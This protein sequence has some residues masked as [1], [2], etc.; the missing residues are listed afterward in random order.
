MSYVVELTGHDGT[1][2]TTVRF[3][4]GPGR[5]FSDTT[6]ANSGLVRWASPSQ[7]INVAR[8]G[9]VELSGDAGTLVIQNAP[10]DYLS[11]G[12]WDSLKDWA[13]QRASVYWAPT[14]WA[15]KTLLASARLQQPVSAMAENTLT[16]PM[17]DPRAGLDAALQPTK[18]AGSNVGV[19]GVEGT[20]DIKGKGK[21]ILYGVVSNIPGVRVNESK[22]IY[23][24]ADKAAT[25]LCVRDGAFSLSIGVVR[26]N[27]A[28]MQ[29]TAPD[30]GKYDTYAG[31]EGTFVRLCSTPIKTVTFDAQEGAAEANRTHAQIWKRVRT[32]RCG[33]VSGDIEDASVTATDAV[34]P[35]EVG[36]WWANDETMLDAL[37]EVL[38][39]LS[40]YEVE[41]STL[42]WRIAKL[43][44]P[45]G[46][47]VVD[48][49][50]MNPS[51]EMKTKERAL[52]V[53]AMAR[54]D[55]APDGK[56]PFRVTVNWGRN[57]AVMS[58]GDFV[59]GASQRLKEKFAKEWRTEIATDTAIWNPTTRVGRWIDAPELTVYTGYQPGADG[60]TCPH[61]ATEATRL[62]N[63]YKTLKGQFQASF[64][65]DGDRV[66]PGDV[67]SIKHPQFGLTAGPLFRTLQASLTVEDAREKWS[68][69]LA[70]QT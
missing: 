25:V 27:L 17:R 59:D 48:L 54:P 5:S 61:A 12:P 32:E 43:L 69:V 38:S 37:N 64:L 55:F 50:M 30:P 26:A 62:L 53:I 57:Y 47:T 18:F 7:R 65:G 21:P 15:A 67:A 46:A 42:Q 68:L 63:L 39:S 45:S 22:L 29:A 51:L 34:D 9:G 66:I 28:S 41:T 44:A 2:V 36:F 52:V 70:L 14:T 11:V 60:L 33:N 40:G 49:V 20:E 3:A 4:M 16:F 1:S 6:Y 24:L 13:W 58:P 56:P 35:R 31:A 8:G 10:D 23:Q 19:A